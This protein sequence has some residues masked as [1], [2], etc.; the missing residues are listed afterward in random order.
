[1]IFYRF[2]LK[3]VA[4]TYDEGSKRDFA[5]SSGNCVMSS[6]VVAGAGGSSVFVNCRAN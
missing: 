5:H 2:P 6:I 4:S 3:L 1:M